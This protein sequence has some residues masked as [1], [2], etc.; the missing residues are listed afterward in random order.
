MPM[1]LGHEGAGVVLETGDQV[2]NVAPGDHVVL[3]SVPVCG[4]CKA[5]MKGRHIDCEALTLELLIAGTLP[6]GSVRRTLANGDPVPSYMGLGCI[7]EEVLVHED[8]AVKIADHYPLDRACITGCGVITGFGGAIFGGNIVAG[9]TAVVLGCGG[10]GLSAI[11]GA[12]VAGA[13][14][15]I[16]VDIADN[17]LDMAKN[18]GATDL[19]NSNNENAVERVHAITRTG[20]DVVLEC[21]GVG[22]LIQQGFDMLCAGGT[23]VVIGVPSLDTILPI[24]AAMLTLT[25]KIIKGGKYGNHNPRLDIPM[26]MEYYQQ[27]R[28][29]LDHMISKTYTIDQVH[30]AF[31]DM[32]KNVNARGVILFD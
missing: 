19:I 3:S 12:R 18:M 31:A 6:D 20:A 14:R 32:E 17:K 26:L 23:L 4:H 9:D 30:E 22:A 5:C 21:A 13:E 8:Y 2:T 16:A 7:A 15:I 24:P 11:Q 1:V 27:G 25:G 29:D 28:L 10:V